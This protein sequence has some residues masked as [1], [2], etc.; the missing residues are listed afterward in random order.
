MGHVAVNILAKQGAIHNGHK[1]ILNY[2]KQFGKP[3]A[4][5]TPN[6]MGWSNYVMHGTP[7]TESNIDI[8]PQL[9]SIHELN[10]ET[11]V[12]ENK[13][14]D[15]KLRQTTLQ[16]VTSFV[17]LYKDQILSDRYISFTIY[18]AT[19]MLLR[20]KSGIDYKFKVDRFVRGPEFVNFF[21]KAMG[22]LMGLESTIAEKYLI[23]PHI[24]KD[25]KFGIKA[26]SRLDNVPEIYQEEIKRIPYIVAGARDRFKVGNNKDLAQELR[27]VYGP[28]RKIKLDEI[29]V[30]EGG[31][32]PG[33]LEVVSFLYRDPKGYTF[34]EDVNYL[35]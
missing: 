15:E 3:M 25:E 33:R 35:C 24:I 27:E 6:P 21:I 26:Q 9:A 18:T 2:T 17:N 34:V 29:L 28:S 10:I 30:Y 22:P 11:V 14:I 1:A 12:L 7:Y 8:T 32:V 5:I 16:Q 20:S 19:S 23:Y 13:M 31:F 4:I